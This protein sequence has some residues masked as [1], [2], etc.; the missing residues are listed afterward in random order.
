M[1]TTMPRAWGIYTH[2]SRVIQICPPGTL[3]VLT[4]QP[5]Y[6]SI[7]FYCQNI[8][9]RVYYSEEKK[10]VWKADEVHVV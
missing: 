10:V 7:Q 1:T 6:I 2:L 5:F 9:P 8:I 3:T 4:D